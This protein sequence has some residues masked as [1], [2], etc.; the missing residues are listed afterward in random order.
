MTSTTSAFWPAEPTRL[1]APSTFLA[2]F[3][4]DGTLESD[5]GEGGI[6]TWFEDA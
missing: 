1:T 3:R 4:W 6:M 5:F 2:M